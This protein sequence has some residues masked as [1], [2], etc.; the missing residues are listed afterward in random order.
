MSLAR[1]APL[2]LSVV[3]ACGSA[4]GTSADEGAAGAGGNAG[5]PA[6][7]TL[8]EPGAP[9]ATVN[10]V[11]SF[12]KR[13]QPGGTFDVQGSAL[14]TN[15]PQK[16]TTERRPVMLRFYDE[17]PLDG[18]KL[19]QPGLSLGGSENPQLV[20]PGAVKI[21]ALGGVAQVPNNALGIPS[22]AL[23]AQSWIP[24][25][26]YTLD[27]SGGAVGHVT[28]EF[29]TPGD[30]QLT[31]PEIGGAPLSVSRKAPLAVAWSGQGDGRPVW[32]HLNQGSTQITCR[33]S[34]K[35]SF[36]I[37]AATM[38]MLGAT[39]SSGD[40][41]AEPD[42]LTVERYTWYVVGSGAGVTLVISTVAAKLELA[43]Q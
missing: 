14:Y 20:K 35:G 24:V 31:S 17:V 28:G 38:A 42:G 23:P 32:I 2:L 21:M 41:S 37:P 7:V 18:C 6:T 27:V 36:E 22:G 34:D 30:L 3:V 13:Q 10:G 26:T 40:P 29:T 15:P 39:T 43:V 33:A 1:F 16:L 11:F 4:G 8:P 19:I 9:P 5:G 25:T 12:E